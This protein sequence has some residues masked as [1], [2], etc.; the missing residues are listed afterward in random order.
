MV[1][2][3]YRSRADKMLSGVCGGLGKYVN[4]DP[5]VVRVLYAA[6]TLLSGGFPGLILYVIL[7]AVIPEEPE[8]EQGWPPP[9]PQWQPPPYPPPYPPQ[10]PPYAPPPPP[11]SPVADSEAPSAEAE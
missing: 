9:P 3:L 5:T 8:G 6:L 11:P 4:L 2:K 10:Q 7:L 1:K